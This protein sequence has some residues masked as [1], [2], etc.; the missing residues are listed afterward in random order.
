MNFVLS[1]F[2]LLVILLYVFKNFVFW[3]LGFLS[4]NSMF[5]V[6]IVLVWI[7]C[8][9]WFIYCLLCF[10]NVNGFVWLKDNGFIVLVIWFFFVIKGILIWIFKLVGNFCWV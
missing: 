8:L 3:F 5:C 9:M 4:V 7:N 6:L 10:I 2:I 1:I